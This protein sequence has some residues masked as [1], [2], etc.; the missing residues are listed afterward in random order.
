VCPT[1][2]PAFLTC[3]LDPASEVTC[4]T[5]GAIVAACEA[6]DREISV[7]LG[8]VAMTTDTECTSCSRSSCCS[9]IEGYLRASDAAAFETCLESC[10]DSAC[11]DDC[12]EAS[13]VAAAADMAL[14]DC[15]DE[16]CAEP[17]ICG[18]RTDD[19]ACITCAKTNCCTELL[20]YALASD[21]EG[22]S[23]CLDPCADQACADACI[24]D[25]PD[26]GPAFQTYSDCALAACPTQC[27]A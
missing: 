24:A 4:G 8:C 11:A 18:A 26:A 15:Q 1:E 2:T 6:E 17:C 25:F 21:V 10:L 27:G 5:D 3:T 7:C 9:Q 23:A 22:F 14:G 16:S 19:T 12:R 20:P 13:P